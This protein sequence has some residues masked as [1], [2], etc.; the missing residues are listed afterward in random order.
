[1]KQYEE[2]LMQEALGLAP[3]KLLL[4]K[5]AMS[6]EDLQEFVKLSNSLTSPT[7]DSSALCPH[8]F[9]F[10]FNSHASLTVWWKWMLSLVM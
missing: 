1:M 9:F 4:A 8:K 6:T 7:A 2:A 5:K 10:S 3:K